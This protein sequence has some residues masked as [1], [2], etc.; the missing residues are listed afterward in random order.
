MPLKLHF[1]WDGP[2]PAGG[3][4]LVLLHGF[5]GDTTTWE[6]LR[7]DLRQH[8]A[9]LAIDLPGHGRSPAP[10]AAAPYAMAACV[11]QVTDVLEGL[12]IGAAWWVGY[13]LGGRVALQVAARRPERVQG[14][15]LVSA[16]AGLADPAQ[17][18]ARVAQDEALARRIEERGVAAFVE[19][20]LAR[21]LFA[22]LRALPPAARAAQRAQRLRNRAWGLANSLRGMGAGAMEPLWDA[23]PGIA[24][25]ALL[26]AG[27]DD[28]KFAR[29]AGE[30]RALLPAGR[31]RILPG[32][33]HSLHVTH[34]EPF[35]EAVAEFLSA[36]P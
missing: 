16:A 34:P 11:E 31:C 5:T 30:M 1:D 19:E 28:P 35:L 10:R 18:A 14:L 6:P 25:P 8:G 4:A 9:T 32:C 17:R 33:G 29:L 21:P 13:S 20:W 36:H 15:V 12:G 27:E 26:L 24:A 7:P 22:G 23:L 3:R 2:P